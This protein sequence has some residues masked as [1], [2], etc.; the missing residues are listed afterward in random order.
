ML[1][2]RTNIVGDINLER[3]VWSI[4][5]FNETTEYHAIQMT[6]MYLHILCGISQKHIRIQSNK[7]LG[8]YEHNQT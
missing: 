2:A 8:N 1:V 3:L 4:S 5:V 6:R 7:T